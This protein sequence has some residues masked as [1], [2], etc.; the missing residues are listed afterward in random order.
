MNCHMIFTVK[1]LKDG[2]V[3]KFKCRLV[4]DGNS[5]QYGVDFDRV[6]ATVVKTA[7]LRLLLTLATKNDYNLSSIDVRQAFLHATAA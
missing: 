2:S 4:A 7:T 5:Q 6:F 3:D 1:R